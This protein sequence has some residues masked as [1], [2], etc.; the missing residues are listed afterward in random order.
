MYGAGKDRLRRVIVEK[1]VKSV[2]GQ[3]RHDA[4]AVACVAAGHRQPPRCQEGT[5]PPRSW[6]YRGDG[7]AESGQVGLA[8]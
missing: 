6:Y 7:P 4:V 8:D 1:F 5:M 2:G 3:P